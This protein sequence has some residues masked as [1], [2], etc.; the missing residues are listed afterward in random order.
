MQKEYKKKVVLLGSYAVGKTAIVYNF[1]EGKFVNDYRATIGV[2]LMT[3]RIELE[4][5]TRITYTIWD[6]AGQL[7]FRPVWK[8]FYNKAS[9]ALLLFDVTR[10]LT[11]DEVSGW[12]ENLINYVPEKIPCILIANKIDLADQRVISTEKG[13]ELAD[14]LGTDYMETSAKTG[15]NVVDAFKKIGKRT[16][17]VKSKSGTLSIKSS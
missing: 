15:E 2:N 1:V 10:E 6:I 3:K 4:N 9:A 16:L 5:N 13:L 8:N 17:E 12:Y 11:Y 7:A 14:S